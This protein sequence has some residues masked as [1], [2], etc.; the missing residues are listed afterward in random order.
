M[1]MCTYRSLS[2]SI[3]I[4][5]YMYVYY[6]NIYKYIHMC[7][8]IYIYICRGRSAAR[9]SGENIAARFLI[10]ESIEVRES[11]RVVLGYVNNETY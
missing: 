1:Y 6:T 5:I 4:Y 10:R 9:R 2:L 3:Y 7:I 8:Y 11:T